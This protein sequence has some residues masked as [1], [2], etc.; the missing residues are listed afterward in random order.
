MTRKYV[1]KKERGPRGPYKSK[2]KKQF[3]PRRKPTFC[4][5]PPKQASS[6][7]SPPKPSRTIITTFGDGS[8]AIHLAIAKL[9]LKPK[10]NK[11][12]QKGRRLNFKVVSFN[13]IIDYIKQH[14]AACRVPKHLDLDK[15]LPSR[16]TFYRLIKKLSLDRDVRSRG[17]QYYN[18]RFSR[19]LSQ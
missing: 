8:R 18:R 5:S 16:P 15:V 7:P 12:K 9:L 1:M 17:T 10:H 3:T 13:E 14:P 19:L 11:Q 2:A 4:C 6:L